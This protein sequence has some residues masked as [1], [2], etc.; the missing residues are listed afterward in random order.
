MLA[1][2]NQRLLSRLCLDYFTL[3]AV[4]SLLVELLSDGEVD[5]GGAGGRGGF[6]VETLAVLLYLHVGFGR[7]CYRYPSQQGV[8]T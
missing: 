8:H 5:L 6:D 4:H 2:L 1:G 3:P 7:R